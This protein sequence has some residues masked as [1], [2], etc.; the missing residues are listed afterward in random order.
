[1]KIEQIAL[2][3]AVVTPRTTWLTV[4]VHCDGATGL[5]EL[6]GICQ[7]EQALRLVRPLAGEI[8]GHGV[9]EAQAWIAGPG[10]QWAAHARSAAERLRRHT[11]MGGVS[12]ALVDL[13]ARRAGVSMA[14]YLSDSPGDYS[15]H[16]VPVYANINRAMTERTPEAAA[17]LATLARHGGFTALKCAPFDGLPHGERVETGLRIAA[18]VRSA[19]GPDGALMVDVHH[20]LDA[21]QLRAAV[22]GLAALN[23]AWLEDAA[24]LHE[25]DMLTRV[26][27]TV[28]CPLAGGEFVAEPATL[29]PALRAG[30]LDVAMPDITHAGGPEAAL[31][32]ARTALDHGAAVT[33]HNPSGP[34]ATAASGQITALLPEGWPLEIMFGEMPARPGYIA[35]AER[36]HD[37]LLHLAPGPGLGIGLAPNLEGDTHGARVA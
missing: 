25:I 30:V 37:G 13:A 26:R 2:R 8:Q 27:E 6:S 5:G 21:V 7:M 10:R 36:V 14:A 20:Q 15:R 16:T 9:A 19:L 18:A 32:L 3:A 24:Q 17:R 1:M 11:A 23:L 35:P 4:Q 33:L 28:G 22:K 34:V 29:L 31:L 12:T